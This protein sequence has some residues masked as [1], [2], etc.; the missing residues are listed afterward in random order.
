MGSRGDHCGSLPS[1]RSLARSRVQ[2]RGRAGL[3]GRA[4]CRADRARRAE[5]VCEL[6]HALGSQ[7][8]ASSVAAAQGRR[9]RPAPRFGWPPTGRADWAAP[10]SLGRRDPPTTS[11]KTL[12]PI[13]AL[14]VPPVG[15]AHHRRR[16]KHRDV[17]AQTTSS[18]GLN[19]ATF[20]RIRERVDV[21]VNMEP[22]PTASP[23]NGA[24]SPKARAPASNRH[25]SSAWFACAMC[26]R[27]G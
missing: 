15:P 22:E 23:P 17:T 20:R 11:R 21:S 24:V 27:T 4:S 10:K 12:W 9:L 18:N 2:R 16:S 19:P 5:R 8:R 25:N 6:G 3:E 26:R 14:F 1:A 7:C 13:W